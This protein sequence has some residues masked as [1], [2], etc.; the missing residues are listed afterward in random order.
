[1]GI[2]RIEI[3][4]DLSQLADQFDLPR[5]GT[6]FFTDAVKGAPV[7]ILVGYNGQSLHQLVGAAD[8]WEL[9]WDDLSMIGG[10]RGRSLGGRL[11]D[12]AFRKT[13]FRTA[14]NPLPAFPHAVGL[15]TARQLAE[16]LATT[17][18]LTLRWDAPDYGI[19]ESPFSLSGSIGGSIRRLVQ[20]VGQPEAFSVDV[21]T[22]GTELIVKQ[23]A[24]SPPAPDYTL[25][26]AELMGTAITYR[27]YPGP[28]Y[29]RLTIIG[30][31]RAGPLIE[32]TDEE[33]PEEVTE[34][35]TRETAAVP[36]VKGR[37]RTTTSRT[38]LRSVPNE[39]LLR[40]HSITEVEL[41]QAPLPTLP[42]P[43][44]SGT[45]ADSQLAQGAGTFQL[46]AL[47][48]FE[49]P[50]ADGHYTGTTLRI[51]LLNGSEFDF[52]VTDYVG[53][54][55]LATLNAPLGDFAVAGAF[56]RLDAEPLPRHVQALAF[57]KVAETRKTLGYDDN[58]LLDGTGRISLPVKL[59]EIVSVLSNV[60]EQS[61]DDNVPPQFRESRRETIT[62][63]YNDDLEL[64]LQDTL[65]EQLENETEVAL[66]QGFSEFVGGQLIPFERR[67][68]RN[69]I[70]D[71][72][73]YQVTTQIF[74]IE[75]VQV[76]SGAATAS[77]IVGTD[78]LLVETDVKVTRGQLPG[79]QRIRRPR[80][81][82][83]GDGPGQTGQVLVEIVISA[84]PDAVDVAITDQN[85]DQVIADRLEAQF[86][87]ASGLWRHEVTIRG[88]ALPMLTKGK[89]LG[90][91]DALPGLAGP[92]PPALTTGRTLAYDE[93]S[94]PPSFTS[95]LTLVWWGPED[96]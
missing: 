4:S 80:K 19:Q 43:L 88:L 65:I 34:I 92:L 66:P 12:R 38:V 37:A 3:R 18:G 47:A 16:E 51:T 14:P 94:V 17:A 89:V 87:A 91:A 55:R 13:Y 26:L 54:T 95:A 57:V 81:K 60:S 64:V 90:W 67:I 8:E 33:L 82:P 63:S 32:V 15:F 45:V 10:L 6:D 71:A 56:W 77:V 22:E 68:V 50:E 2:Q 53:S 41:D 73:Q 83:V 36:P 25:T 78:M 72:N 52:L 20:T 93:R 59:R 42:T 79:P 70:L 96:G 35:E 69:E 21:Y 84:D 76:S 7:E 31:N 39:V 49:V 9:A 23:R 62:Y 48:P 5:V 24:L 29:G 11:V 58:L 61:G 75:T 74:R 40:E 44:L 46:P 28:V 86:R 85:I 1:M 27:K 30:G